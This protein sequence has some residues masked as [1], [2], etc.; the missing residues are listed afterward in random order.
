M[1]QAR[2]K[3]LPQQR[4]SKW[5]NIVDQPAPSFRDLGVC[6]KPGDPAIMD[7]N[8]SAKDLPAVGSCYRANPHARHRLL[9]GLVGFSHDAPMMLLAFWRRSF[10]IQLKALG[11]LRLLQM[12]YFV[13]L[14]RISGC[15]RPTQG[16]FCQQGFL[17]G[18]AAA[19]AMVRFH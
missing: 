6:A 10:A 4:S 13:A 9:R 12:L 15:W 11:W 3:R 19:G 1:D 14:T 2:G 17:A 5:S 7:W 16:W 18:T 8:L